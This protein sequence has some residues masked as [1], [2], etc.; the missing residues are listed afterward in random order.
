MATLA[1]VNNN[2]TA[3]GEYTFTADFNL[4]TLISHGDFG[5]GTLTL[6]ISMD[7]TNYTLAPDS[8]M[9][10][11]TAYNVLGAFNHGK[12]ILTGAT[13]PDITIYIKQI[14]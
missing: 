7:G 14:F 6:E 1:S 4:G 13:N 3:N 10:T 12:L 11:A 5:G 9:T 8:E 2:I